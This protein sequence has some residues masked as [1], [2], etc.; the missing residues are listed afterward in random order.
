MY[1]ITTTT[2]TTNTNNNNNNY[3]TGMNHQHDD[4]MEIKRKSIKSQPILLINLEN[5]IE[6]VNVKN[7]LQKDHRRRKGKPW[8]REYFKL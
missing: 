7:I 6:I 3:N 5:Q 4:G 8:K 1:P 2:T